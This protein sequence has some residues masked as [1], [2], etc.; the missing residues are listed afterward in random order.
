MTPH[1]HPK[2]A[3]PRSSTPVIPHSPKWHQKLA[4]SLIFGLERALTLT[5]RVHWAP[6]SLAAW[7]DN[8]HPRIFCIWHNR[9]GLSMFL[10]R[11][12]AGLTGPPRILA[13]L[14]S[15][16]KDGAFLTA[17]LQSF[18]VQAV[19]GS[20]SRRGHQALLEI[21]SVA[22]KGLDVAITPDGPRGPKY[23]VQDGILAT[24]Q[25][26]GHPIVPVNFS[27]SHK[28]TLRSWDQFQIPLPFARCLIHVGKPIR[29][30]RN[31]PESAKEQFRNHLQK[32]MLDITED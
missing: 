31:L 30:P 7:N 12:R 11:Q 9:L 23:S 8:Q 19:R 5:L 29:I 28:I 2:P 22:Q 18:G 21:V 25:I 1:P 26:T 15:A 32:A 4:A 3:K 24:A 20:S 10:Y 17:V 16:S 27:I 6:G 13:A 14:V